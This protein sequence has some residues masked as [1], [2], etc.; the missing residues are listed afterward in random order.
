MQEAAASAQD[1]QEWRQREVQFIAD[2]AR[3]IKTKER[4]T[5][6][7]DLYCVEWGVKL[8]SL[9]HLARKMLQW[10]FVQSLHIYT[11]SVVNRPNWAVSES[12]SQPTAVD[13]VVCARRPIATMTLTTMMS[14]RHFLKCS[15]EF[16]NMEPINSWKWEMP[17]TAY[18][19]TWELHCNSTSQAHRVFWG[20]K[21]TFVLSL[22]SRVGNLLLVVISA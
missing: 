11:V 12:W 6:R 7:N 14:Y 5:L 18:K 13:R 17:N 15:L 21:S 4:R 20:K 9:T 22:G 8:Y 10:Y 1:R 3:W 2:D 19:L 16:S